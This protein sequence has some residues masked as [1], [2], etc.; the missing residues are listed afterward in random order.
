M[1]IVTTETISGKNLEHLGLVR[2]ATI[3]TRNL[4]VDIGQAFRLMVGGK[5]KTYSRLLESAR[6]EATKIM[7]K[8]ATEMGADAI[9]GVRYQTNS[10][11]Q[12]AAEIIVYGTAV[13]F[14]EGK[15]NGKKTK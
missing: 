7:T 11:I 10:V 4:F 8:Q 5:M 1:Q 6:D 13:K 12:T 2:G 14:I 3:K 15:A 9:V